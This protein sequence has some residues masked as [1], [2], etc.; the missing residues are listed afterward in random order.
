MGLGLERAEGVNEKWAEMI[1]GELLGEPE[2]ETPDLRER[3]RGGA[4]REEGV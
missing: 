2:R 3:D 1:R 4:A